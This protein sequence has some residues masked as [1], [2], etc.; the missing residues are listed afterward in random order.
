VLSIDSTSY[1]K[2]NCESAIDPYAT[3]PTK[4]WRNKADFCQL[5]S[6]DNLKSCIEEVMQGHTFCQKLIHC[7]PIWCHIVTVPDCFSPCLDTYC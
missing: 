3:P 7:R 2:R 5:D 4:S 6:T 1:H